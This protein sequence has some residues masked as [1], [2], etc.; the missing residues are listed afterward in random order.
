MILLVT[1]E[2]KLVTII[3]ENWNYVFLTLLSEIKLTHWT[4]NVLRWL[5]TKHDFDGSWV[6]SMRTQESFRGHILTLGYG[7]QILLFLLKTLLHILSPSTVSQYEL[8]EEL[9]RIVWGTSFSVNLEQ[10]TIYFVPVSCA[11]IYNSLQS[12]WKIYPNF[13]L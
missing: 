13:F 7:S 9:R 3:F 8:Y 12:I 10:Y 2:N 5:E 4:E 1:S 6:P 11:A